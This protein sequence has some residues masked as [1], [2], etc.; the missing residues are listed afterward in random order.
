MT[1]VRPLGLALCLALCFGT[2]GAQAATKPLAA[3]TTVEGIAEYRLANGMQV[4]LAPDNSKPSTTVNVTYRVGSKHE[5]YGETGMAHLLEHLI[6]K[7]TPKNRAPWAEFSKRGLRANGSTWLDRTNYFASFAANND[8]LKWY[9]DW[10]AD[11]MVNSFIARKDLDTEMTVVRNEMEMGEN[12]PGYIVYERLMSSM[13][14]WHN[15]GKSTIGA[16]ADI[17]NVDIPRLQGFY[18]TYYQPDNAVLL[19][20]GRFDEQKA[21]GWVAQYFGEIP[22]PTRTL[23]KLWT[24]EP[25]Q[26]GEREVTVRR[27]G[28]ANYL[29]AA[30]RTPAATHPDTPALQML[31]TMMTLDPSGRLYQALVKS[32][33]A[34]SVDAMGFTSFDPYVMGYFVTLNRTQSLERAREVLLATVERASRTRFTER[35]LERARIS[36]EKAHE[37]TLADSARLAVALSEAIAL[38]DWRAFFLQNDR[39]KAV[40]LADIERV[41]ATY[42]KPENRTLGRFIATDRPDR[43]PIP[44]APPVESLLANWKGGEVIS[45]GEDFDP[46]PRAIESRAMRYTLPSGLKVV[47]WPKKTR[48]GTTHVVL[49]R[50]YGDEKTRTG[51]AAVEELIN[52][53]L[54][55]GARGLDRQAINDALDRLRATGSA[56]LDGANFQTRRAH[57]AALLDLLGRIYREPTFPAEEIELARKEAITAI[58]ESAK[59]PDQVAANALAR[60]FNPYPRSDVRYVPTFAE[61]VAALRAVARSQ[62]VSHYQRMRGFGAAELVI[63]GDFDEAAVRSAIER[64]FDWQGPIRFERVTRP[65]YVPKPVALRLATPDKEN[66]TFMLRT[67]FDFD[68]QAEDYPALL[69][70]NFIVGGSAG[71]RLFVRVREREGLSYNVWSSLSVPTFGR[72]A[73]WTFGFIANPQNA[74]RAEAALRDELRLL[75][76][77]GLSAEEFETQKRAFLAQ[78]AVGR[79]RDAALAVQLATLADA[80]RTF[81]FVEAL[82]TKIA[83]LTKAD[84]DRVLSTYLREESLS[85]VLAGDFSKVK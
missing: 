25:T 69:L 22:R 74:A 49:R 84:F 45:A 33:L 76:Q 10:Q 26:D 56:S 63:L 64:N 48:G 43:V 20:A 11:A 60:H 66:A 38:G 17:E 27:V 51:M 5:N 21:L 53:T 4:L 6:F 36:F 44:A 50:G 75:R 52:A 37:E 57:V 42:F 9:L 34:V 30:Y 23:P 40:T 2:A 68:D 19:I 85:A 55:R 7:G 58:E 1:L 81:A 71:A 82:E 80:D 83:Q 13:Y 47:L 18:R 12:N 78:R 79:A 41:A 70:T 67:A 15:Y 28:D 29:F 24:V 59:D 8:N 73:T 3:V 31:I 61:Q 62:I 46:T 77:G 32:G 65:A 16:R 39:L 14:Q 35:D 72:H 54:M